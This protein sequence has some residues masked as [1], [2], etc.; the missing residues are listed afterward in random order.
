MSDRAVGGISIE[1]RGDRVVIDV[2]GGHWEGSPAEAERLLTRLHYVLGRARPGTNIVSMFVNGQ[3]WGGKTIETDPD[4]AL[5][6]V[7]Q[8][9]DQLVTHLPRLVEHPRS[10]ARLPEADA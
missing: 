1:E 4:Q 5:D 3:L 2:P 10:P 9:L 7:R 8:M 6:D